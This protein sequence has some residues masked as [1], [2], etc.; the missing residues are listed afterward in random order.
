MATKNKTIRVPETVH[1]KLSYKLISTS[2]IVDEFGPI[3]LDR[4]GA[5]LVPNRWTSR[6]RPTLKYFAKRN[7]RLFVANDT[8]DDI[9]M[10]AQAREPRD[11]RSTTTIQELTPSPPPAVVRPAFPQP[12]THIQ[13]ENAAPHSPVVHHTGTVSPPVF[14]VTKPNTTTEHTPAKL[15]KYNWH[16][17]LNHASPQVLARLARNPFLTEPSLEAV[18]STRHDITCKPFLETK[19][20]RAPH[21]RTDQHYARGQAIPSDIL[22]PINIPGIPHD[23]HRYFI[24]FI[25]MNSRYAYVSPLT[26]RSETTQLIDSFLSKMQKQFGHVPTC[27]I[28]DNAGEYMSRTVETMLADMDIAYVP[29][30]AHNPEEDGVA[31]RFK[32]SIMNAVRAALRTA[33]MGWSYWTWALLDTTHKNNQLPHAATLDTPH[34]RWY[35]TNAPRLKKLVY[36]RPNRLRSCHVKSTIKT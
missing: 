19:M 10:F 31:E 23:Q 25:D 12:H 26:V 8:R 13:P 35:L 9:C 28:S 7:K 5:A 21:R 32:F 1:T 15:A 14:D 4:T 2:P 20:R 36:V 22:G 17:I 27:F 34:Q 30:I 18:R 24:S 3:W 16:L 29:I 33:Q 6:I 11:T